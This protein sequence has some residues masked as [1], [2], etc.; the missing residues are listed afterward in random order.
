[1]T[2]CCKLIIKYLSLL[3]RLENDIT[4]NNCRNLLELVERMLV[5]KSSTYSRQELKAMLGLTKWQK[6][7][8]YQEVKEETK[9]KTIPK[10]L[11]QGLINRHL[12]LLEEAGDLSKTKLTSNRSRYRR[13]R[14]SILFNGHSTGQI[15]Y[16]TRHSC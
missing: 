15:S 14:T 2:I 5:Y 13:T 9:L 7:S 10:L 1:M 8:F 11:N 6:T 4:R 12:R 3:R 16:A